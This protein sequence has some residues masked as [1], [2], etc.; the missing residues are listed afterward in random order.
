MLSRRGMQQAHGQDCFS[1]AQA[2]PADCHPSQ[3]YLYLCQLLSDS[4]VSSL[5]LQSCI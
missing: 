5:G 1:H 2:I 4:G 3:V